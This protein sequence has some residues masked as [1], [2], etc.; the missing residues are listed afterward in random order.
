ML[1][2]PARTQ[3]PENVGCNFS[4]HIT[5]YMELIKDIT[6]QPC[7]P[8]EENRPMINS[9]SELVE[10]LNGQKCNPNTFVAKNDWRN[11]TQEEIKILFNTDTTLYQ[12]IGIIQLPKSIC[13]DID[14]TELRN[15]Q[16]VSQGNEIKKSTQILKVLSKIEQYSKSFQIIDEEQIGIGLIYRPATKES[17]T[18]DRYV[19]NY[20]GLHID[21]WEHDNLYNRKYSRNRICFN[22][23]QEDRYITFCNVELS[24]IATM[25]SSK[26]TTIPRELIKIFLEE[27]K[28]Y[29]I[30]K[31]KIRPF[32]GYIFPTEN[33]IHDGRNSTNSIIDITFTLRSYYSTSFIN[34]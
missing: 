13:D 29:P 23:G 11:L 21:S 28:N 1:R 16:S 7:F 25:V 17:S 22:L 31:L 24:T 9:G 15:V 8:F 4:E 33:L 14:E 20:I 30:L 2:F 26:N 27:N 6:L 12:Q 19:Q 32:E 18:F 3:S 34:N 5:N 10:V